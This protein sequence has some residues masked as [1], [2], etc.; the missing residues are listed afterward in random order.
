MSCFASASLTWTVCC[1]SCEKKRMFLFQQQQQNL[2]CLFECVTVKYSGIMWM[3]VFGG[4]M[5]LFQKKW[6]HSFYGQIR[7]CSKAY[8][9]I[10]K[11][12]KLHA[13]FM[14]I[15][16]SQQDWNDSRAYRK[17]CYR[18]FYVYYYGQITTST[19]LDINFRVEL[20]MNIKT[21]SCP[22]FTI[23]FC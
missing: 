9:K 20:V 13:M 5:I 2:R 12:K 8:V 17:H 6:D 3:W 16:H 22:N 10:H 23:I 1:S 15:V 4:G 7:V 21:K 18:L 11:Y 14:E 19:T